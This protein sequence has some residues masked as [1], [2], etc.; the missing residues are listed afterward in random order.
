MV[1]VEKKNV[2][3]AILIYN[4]PQLNEGRRVVFG[5][6]SELIDLFISQLP[7]IWKRI[8][9]MAGKHFKSPDEMVKYYQEH[10]EEYIKLHGL[11]SAE[12]MSLDLIYEV[13]K[14]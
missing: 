10:R 9:Q 13:K 14:L 2:K 12:K 11:E 5:E 1:K 3:T 7:L 8:N 6:I 4:D